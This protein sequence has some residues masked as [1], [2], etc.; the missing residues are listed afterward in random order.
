MNKELLQEIGEALESANEA[1]PPPCPPEA[2]EKL[3]KMT[4]AVFSHGLPPEYAAFLQVMDGLDWN[5]LVIYASSTR[6]AGEPEGAF[7]QGFVEANLLWRDYEPNKE[8]L[9]FAESGLSK[10]A[11]NLAQAE[12]QIL[13]R[14]SMAVVKSVAS[15]DDLITEA[16]G[17]HR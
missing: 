4:Q 3:E 1:S 14:P 2:L 9:I 15:F 8:Y 11:Y 10:Y 5:G 16:L 12:Y 13:D 6:P 7:I 17:S